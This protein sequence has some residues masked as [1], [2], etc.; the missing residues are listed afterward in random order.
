MKQTRFSIPDRSLIPRA[1]A[2]AQTFSYVSYLCP[3]QYSYPQN[4][5]RH[6]L[7]VGTEK[8]EFE[9]GKAFQ[10]LSQKPQGEW[11]FGYLGYDLKNELEDLRT[12]SS[13]GISLPDAFFFKA[14][15]LLFFE[16]DSLTIEAEN[17]QEV[18]DEIVA[19]LIFIPD[20]IPNTQFLGSENQA[21]YSQKVEQ[22]RE[23]IQQGRIYEVN[24]C[25]FFTSET[26]V[27]GIDAF[28]KL[29]ELSPMPFS[30]W[31]K[32]PGF[33]IV[34]AS[35]ERF[36]KKE[37]RKLISQPIKGTALRFEDSEKDRQSAD[38][39]L[40]SEKERAENLMIVDLVRN[41]LARVSSIGSTQ[42]E[43]L[44][45]IYSFPKVHQMISTV[46]SQLHENQAWYQAITSAFP[47][48]SMT[49]A[50]K[51]EAMKVID[52]LETNRRSAF[53]GALGYITP[54]NDFDFNVLIRTL[55]IDHQAGKMGFAVGSAIT[56]DSIAEEEW[57]ECAS[58]ASA[59]LNLFGTDLESVHNQPISGSD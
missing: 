36:L 9:S 22:I 35:P 41:D 2:W 20:Q 42:V 55:F 46:T 29:Q 32:G 4:P 10:T 3:N 24:L 50:P 28:F 30:A 39:L 51:I 40:N 47:M 27:S 12:P 25:Q 11:W 26:T 56:W 6:L 23:W 17:P 45:G 31:L 7:A 59:L 58:K 49:G 14:R 48:G 15:V 38:Q 16:T 57:S 21:T 13:Q 33:E 53:S 1:L 52:E 19:M 44:F 37:G 18:W 8:I 54:A 5:F 43:E 34:S